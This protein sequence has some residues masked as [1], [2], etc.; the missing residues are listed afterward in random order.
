MKYYAHSKEG[1][2]VEEWQELDEHLRGVAERAR[3]VAGKIGL[4][5]M[6]ELI[7]LLHDLGKYSEAFQSYLKVADGI[8]EADED[9]CAEIAVVKGRIDHS[10]AGGQDLWQVMAKGDHASRLA[11]QLMA[12]CVVSHHSGL[13]DCV[14]PIGDDLFTLRMNKARDRTH[15]DEVAVRMDS[16][17]RK[18]VDRLLK[19]SSIQD[20]VI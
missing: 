20:S 14:S 18:R 8:N 9:E 19:D 2:P 4:G 15:I 7:G 11:A 5:N 17:L 3:Q 10:T 13:I 16:V 1:R 12:L 6:G